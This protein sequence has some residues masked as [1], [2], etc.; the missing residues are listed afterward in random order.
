MIITVTSIRLRS[1]WYYF[2]LTMF[3]YRIVKQLRSES[4]FIKMKNTGFGYE[5]YTLSAWQSETD[6]VRFAKAGAHA[7][8]MRYSKN[9]ATEVKTYTYNS[10][11]LP[12]W[13]DAKKLLAEN[14]KVIYFK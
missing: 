12:S 11:I 3:G 5:H 8:A 6:P 10:D 2:K 1:V 4:G 7:E 9:I 13:K 14:A